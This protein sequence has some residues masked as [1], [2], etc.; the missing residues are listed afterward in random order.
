[1]A[2]VPK[3]TEL[4]LLKSS[5]QNHPALESNKKIISSS[6]AGISVAK[7][8]R[9]S[10][11]TLTLFRTSEFLGNRRQEST[12]VIFNI[13]IPLWNN[14]QGKVSQARFKLHQAQADLELKQ[15]ELGTKLNMSYLHLG[16]LINQAKH[17]REK[18]L[19][20]A[21]K[22]FKLTRKGFE[23][24]SL[25]ILT[26]IDANNTYYNAQEH[27]LELLQKGWLELASLRIS[28]GMFVS[29]EHPMTNFDE[30]K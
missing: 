17:Y 6:L 27:Y 8:T 28:A 7:S 16:H 29:D 21:K 18:L 12:G 30:V 20:P 26:L 4:R 2:P 9:Y 10:A 15:R 13:Q 24:G 14:S 25:N 1:L 23:S 19:I 3:P 22:M 11:P 5:L